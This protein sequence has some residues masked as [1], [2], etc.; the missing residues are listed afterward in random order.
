MG[1]DA[2]GLLGGFRSSRY[3]AVV[4]VSYFVYLHGLP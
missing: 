3:V 1:F 4:E 2:S